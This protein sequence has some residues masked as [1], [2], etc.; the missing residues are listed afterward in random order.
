MVSWERRLRKKVSSVVLFFN[1]DV[2]LGKPGVWLSGRLWPSRG[3]NVT[4]VAAPD[5]AFCVPIGY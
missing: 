1:S 5:G 4:V 2:P 3:M